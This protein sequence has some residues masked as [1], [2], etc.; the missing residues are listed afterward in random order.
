[1]KE[2]FQ[3]FSK[4]LS[5]IAAII[6]VLLIIGLVF[7]VI[8]MPLI[9][10]IIN[11]VNVTEDSISV[12]GETIEYNIEGSTKATLTYNGESVDMDANSKEVINEL[13]KSYNELP[14]TKLIVVGE[15]IL[16][17]AIADIVISVI[18]VDAVQR[19][20]RNMAKEDTPFTEDNVNY[21][22]K[23]IP[24]LIASFCIDVVIALIPA[25]AFKLNFDVNFNI[26]I[27]ITAMAVYCLAY[28]FEY[29]VELESKKK[30]RA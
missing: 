6:K 29:G 26:T 22:K 3:K 20:F 23:T 17:L 10:F 16:L 18:I 4:I 14:K 1:M 5:V 7:I 25:I 2:K 15:I 27:L 11:N 9:P 19:L 24:L 12:F 28:I 8:V 30:K 13:V 21:I